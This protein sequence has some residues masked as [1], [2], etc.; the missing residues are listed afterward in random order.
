MAETWGS[1]PAAPAK[2]PAAAASEVKARVK[3]TCPA[4]GAE[5]TWDPA[6]QA[7]VCGFCDTVA[8]GAMDDTSA[9]DI[10]E[11]DLASALRSIPDDKRG[12][13]AQKQ[14]VKCQSCHAISV[15]DATRQSQGCGFCGAT[16][17]LPYEEVKEAFSPESLLPMK[18]SNSKA[19]ELIKRW[20]GSRW[21]APS[22]LKKAALTDTVKGL[23]IPYWTFDA[24]ANADWEA[25]AGYYYYETEEYTDSS[26]NRQ[27][28]QTRYTRWEHVSGSIDHFFDDEL[29]PASLGIQAN[30][31]RAVEPF[32][33]QELQPY[34]P[35]FLSGWVVERYQIDLVA[36][37]QRSRQQMEQQ[38]QSMCRSAVPGDT[39]RNLNVR[40]AYSGQTFKHILAPLW[41][42]QY[43]FGAKNFQVVM[44]GYSGA[45]S[46]DYPK[47][48]VKITLAVLALIIVLLVLVTAAS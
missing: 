40:S 18:V 34:D 21:F 20:Y 43:R 33:T 41:M 10:V 37:A 8:P 16:S 24:Q 7:L 3:H 12:W 2:A 6:K 31:L 4:C 42:L 23:Y 5:A 22:K 47:S 13:G 35:G 9:G 48:W 46:G 27:T 38:V 17:L 32:P 14:S 19:R 26:G 44:N 1:T 28:R 36:A 15:F 45:I 39:Q 29:V 30:H 11:H 25:E